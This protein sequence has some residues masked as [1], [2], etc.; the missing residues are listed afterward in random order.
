MKKIVKVLPVLWLVLGVFTAG[1]GYYGYR[2]LL[3]DSSSA[4]QRTH[5]IQTPADTN[6]Q[7][8]EKNHQ[9]IFDPDQI[10]PV[11]PEEYAAAQLRYEKIVNQ[12][13]IGSIYI[14]SADLKTKILAGMSN[15]NLMVGVGTYRADQVL[16]KGNYGL[17]AHNLVQ[18]GGALGRLP[19]AAMDSLIY[20]TD[21]TRI[22]EYKVTSNQVV[23]Q[24]RGDL[25]EEPKGQEPAVITL[26]RCEGGLNTSN[27]AVVQGTF[28][29][30]YPANSGDKAIQ[31]GLG[32]IQ[33]MTDSTTDP[34]T[35]ENQSTTK[36]SAANTNERKTSKEQSRFNQL[37]RLC[38][39]LFQVITTGNHAVIGAVVYLV[40]MLLLCML[41]LKI[42]S[43]N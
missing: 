7:T 26:L 43:N 28:V 42:H 32:L 2:L 8:K 36:E 1:A 12:W 34:S 41:Q 11:T 6:R 39:F 14:P 27:R 5:H 3:N 18:G 17:L 15:E 29:C 37:E 24:T 23:D 10:T 4:E 19:N 31:E 22:Y 16:G 21:F 35:A 25:L 33:Q 40:V 20:A 9:A 13:G 38:I 30:S